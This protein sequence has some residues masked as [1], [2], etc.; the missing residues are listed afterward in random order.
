MKPS[1]ERAKNNKV[2]V[3]NEVFGAVGIAFLFVV[4]I[5]PAFLF[6]KVHWLLKK[7]RRRLV[8]DEK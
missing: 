6:L 7:L 4:F 5:L 3:C 2:S 8:Y 1:K